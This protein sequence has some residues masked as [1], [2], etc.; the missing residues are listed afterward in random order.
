MILEWS[1][2][3]AVQPAGESTAFPQPPEMAVGLLLQLYSPQTAVP[4]GLNSFQ[5]KE[6][7]QTVQT[8]WL[9]FCFVLCQNL[10][11]LFIGIL[12]NTTKAPIGLKIVYF[13]TLGLIASPDFM[14]S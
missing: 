7:F 5:D 3:M 6:A 12:S 14:A 8:K 4:R 9:K 2:P 11:S 13:M 10:I 1:E